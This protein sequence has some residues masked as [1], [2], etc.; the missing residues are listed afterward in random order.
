[1]RSVIQPNQF[2]APSFSLRPYL[3]IVSFK[4]PLFNPIVLMVP[5]FLLIC[6]ALLSQGLCQSAGS[7]SSTSNSSATAATLG[8]IAY[9]SGPNGVSGRFQFSSPENSEWV[10][11][12]ISM[13]GM[14]QYN[15]TDGFPYHVHEQPISSDG[16]CSSALGHFK[17]SETRPACQSTIPNY[18]QEA[19]LSLR[20]GNL[21]GEVDIF[22]LRYND[23]AIYLQGSNSIVGKSIVIHGANMS[24]IACG[25]LESWVPGNTA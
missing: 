12:V 18:C 17:S 19:E 14:L 11:M 3:R 4:A 15:R 1:M 16:N 7:S 5:T 9:I 23:N 6:L 13:S 25:N 24:R 22:T 21:P 20:H 2:R 10:N 8:A